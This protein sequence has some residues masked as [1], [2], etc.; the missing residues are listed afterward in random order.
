MA[1]LRY[2]L[3]DFDGTLAYR[4]GM[5]TDALLSVLAN[6]RYTHITK[7]EIRPL[8]NIGF[9]WHSPDTPHEA[10]F[11]G[12][13]WWEYYEEYFQE[14]YETFG[15]DKEIAEKISKEVREEYLDIK[16]WHLY[17]DTVNALEG[18]ATNGYINIIVSNHVPEL[19]EIV[20][21][22]GI[23]NYFHKVYSSADIGFE[24][25]NKEFF[26]HIIHDLDIDRNACVLIGDSYDAD[27]AGAIRSK[28]KPILVRK[29]NTKNYKWY[30]ADL[31]SIIDMINTIL[32]NT[33]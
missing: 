3:W 8:L 11:S 20:H 19:I 18:I 16:K 28:I 25:P 1:A 2:V 23:G 17:P 32:C 24:K 13:S 7:E 4:D 9:S 15:I 10:F 5:W 31:D 33:I 30:C 14:I 22:L 21:K 12:K 27:I 6:N 29:E 26:N